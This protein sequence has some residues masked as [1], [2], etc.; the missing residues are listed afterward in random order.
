MVLT[1]IC[2]DL[3]GNFFKVYFERQSTQ[4]GEGKRERTPRRLYTGS[5][6]P[7]VG[8]EHTNAEIMT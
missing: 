3:K 5:T 6:E 7:S 8:L 1:F 4:L 2:T